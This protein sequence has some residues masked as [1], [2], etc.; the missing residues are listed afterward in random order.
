MPRCFPPYLSSDGYVGSSHPAI[1]TPAVSKSCRVSRSVY[2]A[3]IPY[4]RH[5]CCLSYFVFRIPDELRSEYTAP[6]IYTGIIVYS[7]LCSVLQSSDELGGGS[8]KRQD[9]RGMRVGVIRVGGLGYRATQFVRAMGAEYVPAL[10]RDEGKRDNAPFPRP[11][12]SYARSPRVHH[13]GWRR[14]PADAS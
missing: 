5:H 11:P 12:I 13:H 10:S 7:A 4:A 3:S 9:L 6:P 1:D 14:G 8:S 2:W